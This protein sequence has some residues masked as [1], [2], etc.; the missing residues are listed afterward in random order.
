MM[1]SASI[2][3]SFTFPLQPLYLALN[4]MLPSRLF[5]N[6]G[7]PPPLRSLLIP[8]HS[9]PST[10]KVQLHLRLGITAPSLSAP[11]HNTPASRSRY[12]TATS[13]PPRTDSSSTNI[14]PE[15]EEQTVHKQALGKI[16]PKLSITFTCTVEG[17]GER[18]TH[19]FTKHAYEK[20]I[21]LVQCPGCKNRCDYRFP[22]NTIC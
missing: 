4:K 21:V 12:S 15:A 7:I 9:L 10:Y 5:R 13:L 22:Q 8:S 1:F 19:E 11:Y 14:K 6:T 17:C 3:F 18:S 16:V 2:Y 20:G